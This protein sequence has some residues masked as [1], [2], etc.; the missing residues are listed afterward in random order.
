MWTATRAFTGMIAG[1]EKAFA[2]GDK[3]TEA[4]AKE[5]GLTGKPDLAQ[6]QKK[7]SHG[8]EAQDT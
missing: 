5:L 8:P 2:P 4:D 1:A 6:P 3:I 7:D